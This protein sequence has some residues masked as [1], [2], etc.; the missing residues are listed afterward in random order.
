LT[1]SAV[2]GPS[3]LWGS[4]VP[5]FHTQINT[6]NPRTEI[7]P[8]E[9]PV[10]VLLKPRIY[11]TWNISKG[12]PKSGEVAI[13]LKIPLTHFWPNSLSPT[14][15]LCYYARY[16]AQFR[17][18]DSKRVL[19]VRLI[20]ILKSHYR[21]FF[22]TSPF[23]RYKLDPSVFTLSAMG[24]PSP[25]WGWK[26]PLFRTQNNTRALRAETSPQEGP[27]IESQRCKSIESINRAFLNILSLLGSLL[28]V[29]ASTDT[30]IAPPRLPIP[31][32][33]GTPFLYE[34]V[35]QSGQKNGV[36]QRSACSRIYQNFRRIGVLL[37]ETVGAP[38]CLLLGKRDGTEIHCAVPIID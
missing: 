8:S 15:N 33:F 14:G 27:V 17:S 7:S 37:P 13:K 36:G 5:L 1:L 20:Y 10:I 9:G 32:I 26:G 3:P 22:V 23:S 21:N 19:Q 6:R 25:L 11:D 16:S 28:Q 18:I 38:T 29:L 12:V 30:E 34:D 35:V 31:K 4:G 24:G 2:G